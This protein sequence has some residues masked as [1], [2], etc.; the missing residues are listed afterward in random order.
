[1][2]CVII[3]VFVEYQPAGRCSIIQYTINKLTTEL[4]KPRP[5]SSSQ[6]AHPDSD[7]PFLQFSTSLH[8]SPPSLALH[9]TR[10]L[11][12]PNPPTDS[13]PHTTYT[14]SVASRCGS[15]F[16]TAPL[17]RP[18]AAARP[19][20]RVRMGCGGPEAAL[21]CIGEY[22]GGSRQIRAGKSSFEFVIVS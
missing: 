9:H 10:N 7:N 15:G 3:F 12:K 21:R 8:Q 16:T 13:L 5:R 4:N 14:C 11:G 18:A 22:I 20:G 1:M 19:I 6:E 17:A 2:F